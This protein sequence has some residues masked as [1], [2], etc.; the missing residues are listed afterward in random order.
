MVQRAGVD[1]AFVSSAFKTLRLVSAYYGTALGR[2]KKKGRIM[3]L[4]V[5]KS[6]ELDLLRRSAPPGSS[7]NWR[8][9]IPGLIYCNYILVHNAYFIFTSLLPPAAV[10]TALTATGNACI[11]WNDRTRAEEMERD[12]RSFA[13]NRNGGYYLP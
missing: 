10:Q 9:F 5:R 13:P 11:C 4:F 12:E 1:S 2:R 8:S 3:I 6:S 7:Y